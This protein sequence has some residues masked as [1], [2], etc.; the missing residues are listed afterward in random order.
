MTLSPQDAAAIQ[1]ADA[2]SAAVRPI[3][4]YNGRPIQVGSCVLLNLAGHFFA[5]SAAH[6]IEACKNHPVLIGC[7]DQLHQISGEVFYSARGPSGTHEDDSIDAAVVHILGVV[8]ADLQAS[9]LFVDNLDSKP[10]SK[11]PLPYV[12]LGFRSNQSR[13]IG[14]NV[15]SSLERWVLS[16][17]DDANYGTFGI[18]RSKSVALKFF[19]KFSLGSEI[20]KSPIPRGISGGAILMTTQSEMISGVDHRSYPRAKLTAIFIERQASSHGK[21][22]V[23]L[24]TRIGHHLRLIARHLPAVWH[25]LETEKIA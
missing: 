15:R 1:A 16:E 8:P 20:R 5:L 10:L 11:P 19:E 2:L 7:G 3:F 25:E 12:L 6:A 9:C 14:R 13:V 23:L 17:Y 24:G 18:D 22:A 4:S 21:S